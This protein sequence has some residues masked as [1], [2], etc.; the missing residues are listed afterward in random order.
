M[1]DRR[2]S[3]V[4]LVLA[5]FWVSGVLLAQCAGRLGDKGLPV[6]ATYVN[7]LTAGQDV[8]RLVD[9]ECSDPNFMNSLLTWSVNLKSVYRNKDW[10]RF[11]LIDSVSGVERQTMYLTDSDHGICLGDTAFGEA[12]PESFPGQKCRPCTISIWTG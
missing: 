11:L 3:W 5:I 4:V 2:W 8:S 6:R 10:S 12:L 7:R 9:P 1:I